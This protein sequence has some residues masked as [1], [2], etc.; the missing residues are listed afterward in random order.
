[1]MFFIWRSHHITADIFEHYG[2]TRILT[3]LKTISA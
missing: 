3:H 1:V 2:E